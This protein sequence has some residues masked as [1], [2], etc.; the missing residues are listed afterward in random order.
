MPIANSFR[1]RTAMLLAAA[2]CAAAACAPLAAQLSRQSPPALPPTGGRYA[3]IV[4]SELPAGSRLVVIAGQVGADSTGRIVSAD[5]AAQMRTA[6]D[7]LEA[8]L[9]A[10]G[11]T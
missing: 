6:Y 8:A 3:H 9:A 1:A 10:A 7:N 5:A 4:T 2:S 11:A